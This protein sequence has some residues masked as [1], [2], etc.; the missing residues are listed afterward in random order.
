M[1]PPLVEESCLLKG[2]TVQGS[3]VSHSLFIVYVVTDK[4]VKS[5]S[6]HTPAVHMDADAS[7]TLNA[8]RGISGS[9]HSVDPSHHPWGCVG[10]RIWSQMQNR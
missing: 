1:S 4:C 8:P 7:S 2:C 6:T 5:D 9:V 3:Q 10:G